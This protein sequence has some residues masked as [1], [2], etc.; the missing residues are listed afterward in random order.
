VDERAWAPG[1]AAER[2]TRLVGRSGQER[3]RDG[4][5]R[6]MAQGPTEERQAT[7]P[8]ARTFQ[9]PWVQGGVTRDRTAKAR[10][11]HD[12]TS[13]NFERRGHM[14]AGFVSKR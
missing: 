3:K 7:S 10:D 11:M 13:G 8:S 9:K 14:S 6:H 12:R 1:D 2:D 5:T 4:W